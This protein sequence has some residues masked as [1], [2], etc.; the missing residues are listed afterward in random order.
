MQ[1]TLGGENVKWV[2]RVG[3]S[4]MSDLADGKSQSDVFINDWF[5]VGTGIQLSF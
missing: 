1:V 3:F 5:T 4:W 2:T